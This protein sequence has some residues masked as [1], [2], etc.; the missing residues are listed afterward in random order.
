MKKLKESL[1]SQF[2]GYNRSGSS[3]SNNSQ[4]KSEKKGKDNEKHNETEFKAKARKARKGEGKESGSRILSEKGAK[5]SLID[6]SGN[7]KNREW[8][9]IGTLLSIRSINSF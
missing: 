9:K 8:K 3:S 1:K 6:K 4:E 7:L 2:Q 5:R